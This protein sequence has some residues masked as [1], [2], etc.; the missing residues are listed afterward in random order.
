M[1]FKIFFIGKTIREIKQNPG[2]FA[3]EEARDAIIGILLIPLI[4]VILGLAF[5]FALGFTG[6]LGGP[7][8][9]FKIVFVLGLFTS[10]ILGLIIYK[11][12]SALRNT[13]KKVV[14][15]TVETVVNKE[16]GK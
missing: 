9:F 5:I 11:L 4:I 15:K 8:L 10:C 16:I 6:F 3:G 7:Y 12:T 1:L 2:N 14:N 13:T